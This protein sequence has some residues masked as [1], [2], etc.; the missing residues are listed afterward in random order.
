MKL[1]A[2][3]MFTL[4]RLTVRMGWD[5][6][7]RWVAFCCS[8]G[9]SIIPGKQYKANG[10]AIVNIHTRIYIYIRSIYVFLCPEFAYRY[11]D[12]CIHLTP[13]EE[14]ISEM[15]VNSPAVRGHVLMLPHICASF[16]DCAEEWQY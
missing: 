7:K 6:C 5:T 8:L 10:C 12:K 15:L 4:C 2:H 11:A 9:M 14:Q 16:K 1:M 13:E 3:T